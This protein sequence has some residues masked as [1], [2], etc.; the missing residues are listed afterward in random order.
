MEGKDMQVKRRKRKEAKRKETKVNQT[1]EKQK[2]LAEPSLQCAQ[3]FYSA[4]IK[5][6]HNFAIAVFP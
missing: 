1:S 4:N 5:P 6:P 3:N 2:Q